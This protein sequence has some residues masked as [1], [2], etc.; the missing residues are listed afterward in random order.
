[1]NWLNDTQPRLDDYAI[2]VPIF[3]FD[4]LSNMD[5]RLGPEMKSTGESIYTIKDLKEEPTPRGSAGFSW[6]VYVERTMY[7][8]L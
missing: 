3:N 1:V 2:E 7:S 4:K 6:Q 8:S 5:K